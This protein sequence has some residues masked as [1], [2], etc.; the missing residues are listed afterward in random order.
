MTARKKPGTLI[1]LA[2]VV[3]VGRDQPTGQA[4][5]PFRGTKGNLVA[6]R[7]RRQQFRTLANGVLGLAGAVAV[8]R[9]DSTPS[10]HVRM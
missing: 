7:L 6:I 3:S 1:D 8:R 5:L 2:R 10:S 4:V 9:G